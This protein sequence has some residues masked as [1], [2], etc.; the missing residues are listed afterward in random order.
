MFLI[1]SEEC[2]TELH[3]RMASECRCVCYATIFVVCNMRSCIRHNFVASLCD[4][5]AWYIGHKQVYRPSDRRAETHDGRGFE[6]SITVQQ[7]AF[8]DPPCWCLPLVAASVNKWH[9]RNT[10]LYD[11]IRDAILTCAQKP[12]WVSLIYRTEPTTK[13]C[14]TEK[15]KSND[16]YAQKYQ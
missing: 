1:Y 5:I 10:I 12:T 15:V 16:G 3:A 2:Y 14:K 11:T 8:F 7:L 13:K 9:M 6:I 4:K